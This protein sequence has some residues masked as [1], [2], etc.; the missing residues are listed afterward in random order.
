MYKD[1][2]FEILL[3]GILAILV[4]MIF[5]RT[6]ET[7]F[8]TYGHLYFA[9]EVK[10]Q[11]VGPFGGIKTKVFES[12]EFYHPFLWHWLISRFPIKA[13]LKKQKYI[14]PLVDAFLAVCLYIFL[15]KAGFRP[16]EALV[17]YFLYLFTPIFFSRIAMGPRVNS[18]TPR[19][20]AEGLG[21][22]LSIMLILGPGAFHKFWFIGLTLF[23]L[24][25]LASQKFAVQVV[26][27]LLPILAILTIDLM[28]I[29]ILVFFKSIGNRVIPRPIFACFASAGT[30]F[31]FLLC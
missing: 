4:R 9:S 19:L 24:A 17:G 5:I 20:F 10:G 21:F 18:L 7:N 12:A 29:F 8:D 11:K 30:A 13:V 28:P 1:F 16:F 22:F 27:L 3:L 2:Y 23:T 14:N 15:T 6:A 26:W 25:L 31:I